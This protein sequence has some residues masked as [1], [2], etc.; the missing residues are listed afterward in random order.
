[1]PKVYFAITAIII[2]LNSFG[3][4]KSKANKEEK[5]YTYFVAETQRKVSNGQF[6]YDIPDKYK[7]KP[8]LSKIYGLF[9]YEKKS[10]SF[11]KS[12]FKTYL[13]SNPE[14]TSIL[15][16]RANCLIQILY[17]N[18]NDTASFFTVEKDYKKLI[19]EYNAT[20]FN[21]NLGIAYQLFYWEHENFEANEAR[22]NKKWATLSCQHLLEFEKLHKETKTSK[23]YISIGKCR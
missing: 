17:Q 2:S 21:L 23:E 10:Y 22:K 20:I 9:Y 1:M 6:I 15:K 19:N 16:K 8:E 7:D 3:Q 5:E 18:A 13:A 14:D 12:Y 11:A 4:F